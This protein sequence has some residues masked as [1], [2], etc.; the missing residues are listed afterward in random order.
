MRLIAMQDSN[1]VTVDGETRRVTWSQLLP[2]GWHAVQWYGSN[3]ELEFNDGVRPNVALRDAAIPNLL[4]G[5]W[6]AGM[7]GDAVMPEPVTDDVAKARA[8]VLDQLIM[9]SAK[10]PA[11]SD[12]V[13]AAAAALEAERGNMG[14]P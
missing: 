13:K 7:P 10:S 14:Q 8:E 12:V 3:G 11:A 9:D 5:L 2:E 1:T 4:K 6:D